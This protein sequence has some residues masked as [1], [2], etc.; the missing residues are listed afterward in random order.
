[1]LVRRRSRHLSSF[2]FWSFLTKIE[3]L[4]FYYTNILLFLRKLC[5]IL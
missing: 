5:N 4:S 3:K 1:M 2:W